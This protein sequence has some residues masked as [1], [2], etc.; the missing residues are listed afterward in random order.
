[1]ARQVGYATPSGFVAAFRQIV[2]IPPA[3]YFGQAPS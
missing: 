1:L 3:T 2:G